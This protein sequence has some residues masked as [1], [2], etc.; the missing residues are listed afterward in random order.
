MSHIVIC[1]YCGEKFDRDKEPTVEVGLRRYAH[2]VCAEQ[3]Q[4]R[5]SP[6]EVAAREEEKD[7]KEL[8]KY[9]MELFNETSISARIR[10]QIMDYRKTY[11]YSY[12]GILK[13][14]KW[15]FEIQNNSIE[16]ANDGIGIVPFIYE[17]ALTYYFGIY[18]AALANEEY[19]NYKAETKTIKIK[20]P[21]TEEKKRKKFKLIGD[22]E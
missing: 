20:S 13:T 9:I 6:E 5:L 4:A 22:E 7:L 3:E 1:K 19:K 14:L 16:N 18:S 8:E 15:W 2:K 11:Q 10:K 21:Q 12:S 17:K